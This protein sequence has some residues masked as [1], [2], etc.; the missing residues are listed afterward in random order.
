[1]RNL[2]YNELFEKENE[3][4]LLYRRQSEIQKWLSKVKIKNPLSGLFSKKKKKMIEYQEY[5]TD[6]DEDY[7][8]VLPYLKGR[9]E[10]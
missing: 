4:A 1:M 5:D 3:D 7:D 6:E 2:K 8:D 10:Y 9:R